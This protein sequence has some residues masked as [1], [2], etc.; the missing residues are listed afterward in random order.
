M[1]GG[2]KHEEVSAQRSS[3]MLSFAFAELQKTV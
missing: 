2:D 1:K 3:R